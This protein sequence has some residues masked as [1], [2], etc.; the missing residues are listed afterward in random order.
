M[1]KFKKLAAVYLIVY[2]LTILLAYFLNF[3]WYR[4]IFLPVFIP[5]LVRLIFVNFSHLKHLPKDDFHG[6]F[7][8][9]LGFTVF[10]LFFQ[11]GGD[12]GSAYFFFG[13]IHSE[14]EVVFWITTFIALMGLGIHLYFHRRQV[15]DLK[16]LKAKKQ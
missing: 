10:N 8:S 7:L 2:F 6:L 3:G 12:I 4:V 11:D 16:K 14:S 9:S 5:Y 15:K 13:F 1:I